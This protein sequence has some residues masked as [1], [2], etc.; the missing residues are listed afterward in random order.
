MSDAAVFDDELRSLEEHVQSCLR[1]MDTTSGDARQ[2]KYNRA[3]E[4]LK[5]AQRTFHHLKVEI[6]Q[7]EPVEAADYERRCKEHNTLI[8]QLKEQLAA[9]KNEAPAASPVG[10][11]GGAGGAGGAGE[12]DD[13]KGRARA[14]KDRIATTQ[15]HALAALNRIEQTVEDTKQVGDSTAQ[16][17]AEQTE[18]MHRMNDKLDKLDSEVDRAKS[19]LNAFI[20][21]MMTD[22]IILCF[23]L[24]VII[25][26][27]AIVIIKLKDPDAVNF[28][29]P[30][31]PPTPPPTPAPITPPPATQR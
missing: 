31:P 4:L 29:P 7:L 21:R 6:R 10:G 12:Y 27:I 30:P 2:D 16:K 23:I 22:K 24:L 5:S 17:L 18:Q 14:T 8:T 25:A 28:D 11:H 26:V 9:K 3:Q 19:E 13:G 20:R 15:N 1:A